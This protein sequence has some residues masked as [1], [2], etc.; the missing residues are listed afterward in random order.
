MRFYVWLAKDGGSDIIL[1]IEQINRENSLRRILLNQS[2]P[3]FCRIVF[4]D[5]V[6]F[7]KKTSHDQR[8]LIHNLTRLVKECSA[9]N[10]LEKQQ[11]VELPTGDGMALALWGSAE[12]PLLAALELQRQIK[13]YNKSC[14]PPLR[15]EVRTGINSGEIFTLTDINDQRNI[16]GDGINKA[17]RVMDFG[18]A[19]HILSSKQLAEEIL[20]FNSSLAPL[21]HDAGLFSDKHGLQH[22]VYNIFDWEIGNPDR[23]TRNLVATDTSPSPHLWQSIRE[24]ARFETVFLRHQFTEC[25]HLLLA[26]IK[27]ENSRTQQ[28]LESCSFDPTAT[29]RSLRKLIGKGTANQTQEMQFSPNLRSVLATAWQKAGERSRDVIEEDFINALFSGPECDKLS[30]L[31][32]QLEINAEAFANFFRNCETDNFASCIKSVSP[33][34]QSKKAI[35]I[36]SEISFDSDGGTLQPLAEENVQIESDITRPI[37]LSTINQNIKVSLIVENG[38][39]QG[40]TFDFL[41]PELFIVGRSPDANF[42]LDKSDPCVSRKHF[43]IEIVPPCCYIK[44]F[45]SL[46]GTWVNDKKCDQAQLND[47]DVIAAGKTRFRVKISQSETMESCSKCS[48]C[49]NL[50]RPLP[51]NSLQN[52]VCSAC[53][54]EIALEEQNKFARTKIP[55]QARCESCKIDLSS[56]AG[57]DGRGLALRDVASYLCEDC[58]SK[59][60]DIQTA[61]K[62]GPYI[63]I[64]QLGHGGMGAVYLVWNSNTCRIGALKK[65][66]LPEPGERIARRFVREMKIMSLLN[67]ANLVRIFEDGIDNGAPY[68]VSEY[69]DQ[70]S[71]TRLL[72]RSERKLPVKDALILINDVLEGLNYF[73]NSG[74]IHRDIKPSNILLSQSSGR[75]TAKIA[76]FGLARSFTGVGGTKLTRANEFAGSLYY[77][78]PEQI[79]NFSKVGP[80]ADIYSAGV[81]LYQMLSGML[82]YNFGNQSNPGNLK[83]SLLVVL[84]EPVIPIRE[85]NQNISPQLAALVEKAIAKKAEN[86]FASAKA[87]SDEIKKYLSTMP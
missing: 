31:L 51:D 10:Q 46:N 29:R 25:I 87:F 11:R 83:D 75:L 23:P 15:I 81:T 9:I 28:Y 55:V 6:G 67:H 68:F 41:E 77:T 62:T 45:R 17:Q 19:G 69:L 60:T 57:S 43:M 59:K 38:P 34:L 12:L 49:G 53:Q 56:Q 44:D 37:D 61:P 4:V 54:A 32:G 39:Q 35:S 33:S 40:K 21:L 14:P 85:R 1:N 7:S 24:L 5:I 65:I 73:H 86:R 82:P 72:S 64:E 27:L 79:I 8:L 76:D 63:L 42:V 3:G 22:H 52:A 70:G 80:A 20:H 66:L 74:H 13:S 16:V 36:E 30:S 50:Y 2:I 84:E 48:R 58:I 71:L 26:L 18:N 78:P 47:G